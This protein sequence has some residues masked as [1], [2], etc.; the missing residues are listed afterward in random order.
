MTVE[1]ALQSYRPV[2]LDELKKRAE[3]MQRTDNKYVLTEQQLTYFLQAFQHDFDILHIDGLSSFAYSSAYWDSPCLQTYQDHNKGRR[4]RYK[5]RFR[6]YRDNDLYFFE[7]KIKGFRNATHKYRLASGPQAYAAS[8]LPTELEQFCHDK[9]QQHYGRGP[10]QPLVPSIRVDYQRTTLVARQG[11]QRITLDNQVSFNCSHTQRCLPADRYIVEVKSTTGQSPA[12]RWL[13]R[14]QSHPVQ[15]CSKYSMGINL[16]KKTTKN[17]VFA[18][19]LRRNFS[20]Q[21][22]QTHET[23]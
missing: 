19:V 7:V 23:F 13:Q 12:D 15:R 18:P 10:V 17:S 14:H 20:I 5:V 16:L 9:L 6:H 2:S 21:V 4:L 8:R 11:A 22:P 3:L 1:Q